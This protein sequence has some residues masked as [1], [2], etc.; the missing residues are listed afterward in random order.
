MTIFQP[1]DVVTSLLREVMT[2]KRDNSV[3]HMWNENRQ[4]GLCFGQNA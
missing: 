2:K 4:N 1:Y 3:D